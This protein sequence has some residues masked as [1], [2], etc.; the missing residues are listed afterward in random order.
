MNLCC[1]MIEINPYIHT[2][3]A[4]IKERIEILVTLRL[5]N[6]ATLSLYQETLSKINSNAEKRIEIERNRDTFRNIDLHDLEP[7]QDFSEMNILPKMYDILVDQ[8]PFLRQ[9]ITAG[10]YN[11]VNHYLDV[12]FRL[13]REDYI[14]PLRE[15]IRNFRTIIRESNVN[16][17]NVKH[18]NE[19]SKAIRQRLVKIE[20]LNIFFDVTMES[21]ILH[22][23]GIVHALKMNSKKEI[24]WDISKKLM[25]GSLVCLSSDFFLT[26]CLIGTVCERD[27]KLLKTGNIYIKFEYDPLNQS[28]NN[29]PA[30]HKNY[31]MLEATAFFESYRHVLEALVSFKLS[32]ESEFPFREHLVFG[33]NKQID[34]PPY[35]KNACFDFR[36]LL[37]FFL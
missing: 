33:Q 19:L 10:A 37:I 7:E 17:S 27:P 34:V 11:D 15:G 24:N 32:P 28:N 3:I 12:Q 25:F 21:E 18:S 16:V 9:N 26:E 22:N 14:Q 20:S 5:N 1:L 8:T 23:H 29:T 6:P 2:G 30:T 31:I 13:L 4:P 36:F 35:L